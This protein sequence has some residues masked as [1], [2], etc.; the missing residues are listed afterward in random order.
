[1]ST[2]TL[3]L[4][5]IAFRKL[6]F[7]L[8]VLAVVAA[9]G[10]F[11]A[12]PLII[13]GHAVKTAAV[14]RGLEDETRKLMLELGFNLLIVHRDAEMEDFW[15]EDYS[16]VDMPEDY[17][18]RLAAAPQLTLVNHLVATLQRRIVW[19]QRRVLLV[20][21]LPE[22]PQSHHKRSE[23]R[24]HTI[25]P[26]TAYLGYELG[27]G[28][29][30]GETI[31]VLGKQLRIAKILPEQGSKEDITI[32]VR[33]AD[34]QA[35]LDKPGKINQI[36]AYGCKCDGERL[37]KIRKQLEEVLPET[38]ITEFRSLALVRAEQRDS[39]EAAA[40]EVQSSLSTLAGIIVPL[41]IVICGVALEFLARAN[42]RERRLEIG[43]LRALG[44]GAGGIAALFLGRAALLGLI[45]G[46]FGAALGAAGAAVVVERVF[47]VGLSPWSSHSLL[48]GGAVLGAPLFGALACYLP[49]LKA[50]LQDPAAVLRES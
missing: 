26:G 16:P 19:N 4:K 42:V 15:A 7:G 12:A 8:S 9:A 36:L 45:G 1:M 17:V 27:H 46:V 11:V 44:V 50:M 3:L 29:A 25:E 20:G 38:K 13:D 33:L 49:A 41:V 6:Q 30:V 28:R 47:S 2:F 10:V 23:P 32:A 18:E 21:Y 48:L 40:R 43:A 31:E 37:P 22:T 14:V 39:V 5:E 34:A 35:A 24:G